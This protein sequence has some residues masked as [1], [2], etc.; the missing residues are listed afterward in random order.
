MARSRILTCVLLAGFFLP[1]AAR[2]E[3]PEALPFSPDEL[4]AAVTA[5]LLSPAENGDTPPARVEPAGPGAVTVHV[6]TRSRVVAV[7]DRT[8][9]AAARV[10]ALVIAELLTTGEPASGPAPTVAGS[11]AAAGAPPPTASPPTTV[12]TAPAPLSAA[13]RGPRLSATGG[14]SKGI[15]ADE[16]LS[17][18]ADLDVLFALPG[19]LRLAPSAGLVFLP[20][21]HPGAW[22]Q[23]SYIAGVVRALFGAS[24]GPVDVLGGPFGAVYSIGG[25]TPHAGALFGGE[26]MARLTAPIST[27]LRLTVTGRA[28]AYGN[29]TRVQFLYG[30]SFATPRVALAIGVGLAWEWRS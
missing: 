6:G 7:G 19:R 18:T 16:P 17:G 30:S 4:Q 29:R 15:G 25:A 9:A 24:F 10:V 5:R 28:D 23:V 22:D 21:R 13:P 11:A 8:G 3:D 26:A 2:A 12:T 1:A 14:L 27:R 20:T